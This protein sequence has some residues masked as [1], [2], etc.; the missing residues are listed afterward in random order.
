MIREPGGRTLFRLLVRD[1]GGESEQHLLNE[2]VP[3]WCADAALEV[4]PPLS[5]SI[6]FF[7]ERHTF[8][9]IPF[10][11]FFTPLLPYFTWFLAIHS[12]IYQG[13]IPSDALHQLF[14]L[15]KL[16]KVCQIF[17]DSVIYNLYNRHY[18]KWLEKTL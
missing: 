4:S 7:Y 5:S 6:L 8:L 3:S 1:A 11:Y 9:Q 10:P 15:S 18:E 14:C 2:T 17:S 16:K 12:E 13:R